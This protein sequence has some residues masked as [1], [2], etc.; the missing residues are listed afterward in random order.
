MREGYPEENGG[1]AMEGKTR[2][3]ALGRRDRQG[4]AKDCA[5]QGP[6]N[7][8]LEHGEDERRKLAP[9][10]LNRLPM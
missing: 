8:S 5:E 1:S 3:F 9:V 4:R 2:V 7:A 6:P 10:A